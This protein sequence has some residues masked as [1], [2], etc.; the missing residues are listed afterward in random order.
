MRHDCYTT[1]DVQLKGKEGKALAELVTVSEYILHRVEEEG[2]KEDYI[3]GERQ[4]RISPD[5]LFPS[6]LLRVRCLGLPRSL[7]SS[8][9]SQSHLDSA[10]LSC[11]RCCW[12]SRGL[13]LLLLFSRSLGFSPCTIIGVSKS[14]HV[15]DI[16]SN[17]SP[18]VTFFQ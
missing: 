11:L 8:T 12:V 14:H 9:V 5:C 17:S 10:S 1:V 6:S 3:H 15:L 16:R 18:K 13:R 4:P 7:P 2:S